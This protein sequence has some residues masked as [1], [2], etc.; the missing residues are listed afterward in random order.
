M[1]LLGILV[2]IGVVCGLILCFFVRYNDHRWYRA[3]PGAEERFADV[4]WVLAQVERK[5]TRRFGSC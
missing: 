3:H 5:T 1:V 2:G 4:D